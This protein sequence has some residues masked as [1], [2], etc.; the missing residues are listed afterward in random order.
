MKQVHI[1]IN[2]DDALVLFEYFQRFG[3]A[4]NLSF[5][6]AA[7]YIALTK[8]SAQ[9]DKGI[10]AISSSFKRAFKTS[11]ATKKRPSIS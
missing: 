8:I 3:D 2:E 4:G 1:T 10:V 5:A 9:I 11:K 6:H 7:E